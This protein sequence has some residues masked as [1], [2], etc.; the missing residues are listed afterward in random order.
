MNYLTLAIAV[1]ALAL[2]GANYFNVEAPAFGGV[3][4]FDALTLS[5]GPLVVTTSNTATS[6]ATIGCVNTYA[7]S[8]ATAVKIFPGAINASAS[9]TYTSGAA[10]FVIWA[11]GSCP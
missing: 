7:T 10:G 1:I 5:N 9:S 4:N 3:T 6:S 2:G 11:Y 8:T